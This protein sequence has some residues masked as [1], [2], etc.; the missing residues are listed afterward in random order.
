MEE[1][2]ELSRKVEEWVL[3]A[4]VSLEYFSATAF[5]QAGFCVFQGYHVEGKDGRRE[6]DVMA[7]CTYDLGE[8]RLRLISVV[9]CKWS[10]DNPWAVFTSPMLKMTDAAVISQ[11]IGN[12]LGSA[13][14]WYM[15]GDSCLGQMELFN[16]AKV[17]AFSGRKVFEGGNKDEFYGS[18]QG[19]VAKAVA[20]MSSYNI[21]DANTSKWICIAFPVI[22]VD[23]P[24]FEITYD[25]NLDQV[26]ALEVN[27]TTIRWRGSQD[28]KFITS[29]DIVAKKYVPEFVK[30]LKAN[31]D[32]IEERAKIYFP[33]ILNFLKTRD[34]DSLQIS[35]VSRGVGV[36]WF[37]ARLMKRN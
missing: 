29:V 20:E 3:K 37:F 2:D 33:H 15:A 28:W 17:S 30:R 25:A 34:M 22:V 27:H 31:F 12:E 36:P 21:L 24:I 26:K 7:H 9:E 4:G 10:K 13:L 16:G 8:Y 11:T 32:T 18:L 6:I 35:Q 19:V 5:E 1:A 14:L 23:A